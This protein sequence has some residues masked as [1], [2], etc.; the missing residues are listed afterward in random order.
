MI[1]R[2]LRYFRPPPVV[3]ASQLRELLAEQSAFI[4]QKTSTGY[5]QA[6]TGAF[7]YALFQEKVFID[8]LAICRWESFA[9]V[10]ADALVMTEAFLR[11]MAGDRAPEV[12]NALVRWYAEI[13]AGY[14]PPAHRPDGWDDLVAA[15][16]PRMARAQMAAPLAPVDIAA[17]SG[18]RMFDVLPIHSTYSDADLEVIQGAVQFLIVSLWQI[19][20]KR[21]DIP[22]VIADLVD[23]ASG[24]SA[25]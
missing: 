4:A 12:A 21:V 13:L 24:A 5:C 18:R 9:A 19:L 25:A 17:A 2:V 11:P 10:L 3:S 1:D 23:P 7:S 14:S 6:K 8:A 16:G 20:E 15:F 22:A